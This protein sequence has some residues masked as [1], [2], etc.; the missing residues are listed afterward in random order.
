[1]QRRA[2]SS[3]SLLDVSADY[4]PAGPIIS[5]R[6]SVILTP[7]RSPA[8]ATIKR[9]SE[10]TQRLPP[11]PPLGPRSGSYTVQTVRTLN[12]TRPNLTSNDS[13]SLPSSH[14]LRQGNPPSTSDFFIRSYGNTNHGRRAN[15]WGMVGNVKGNVQL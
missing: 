8:P 5:P 10:N 7:V 6:P 13:C 2:E 15:K 12:A 4:P 1:M 3:L 9:H 14:S 11:D